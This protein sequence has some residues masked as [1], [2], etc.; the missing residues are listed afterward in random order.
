MR[1]RVLLTGVVDRSHAALP[2]VV[3]HIL[4]VTPRC[5]AAAP[6]ALRQEQQH[7]RSSCCSSCRGFAGATHYR[8][9]VP[10]VCM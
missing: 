4:C 10:S 1:V 2:T 9:C 6:C 8:F 3:S 7:H 5:S